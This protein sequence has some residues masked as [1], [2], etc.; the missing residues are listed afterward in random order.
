MTA[1]GGVVAVYDSR[2]PN[3]RNADVRAVRRRELEAGF[4][5]WNVS[6]RRLTLLP[7]LSRRLGRTTPFAYPALCRIPALRTRL[8]VVAERPR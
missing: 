2:L 4:A 8:L 1:P 5:G 6:V 7:P 3:P